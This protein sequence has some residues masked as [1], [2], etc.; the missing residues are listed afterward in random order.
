MTYIWCRHIV[1]LSNL[2]VELL[3]VGEAGDDARGRA[4]GQLAVEHQARSAILSLLTDS[5]VSLVPHSVVVILLPTEI[6]NLSQRELPA[7]NWTES[8]L[9]IITNIYSIYVTSWHRNSELCKWFTLPSGG[10]N[11]NV[12]QLLIFY[13]SGSLWC[14]PLPTLASPQLSLYRTHNGF[15]L[16]RLRCTEKKL[17]FRGWKKDGTY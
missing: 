1:A 13:N 10:Y 14:R 8:Q 12:G 2:L 11:A 6:V 4:L 5:L 3:H 17:R 7:S 9:V 15:D 16:N